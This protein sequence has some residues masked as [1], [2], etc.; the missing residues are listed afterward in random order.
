[1]IDI[2]LII[3]LIE[4]MFRISTPLIIAAMGTL[5]A[6][7]SGVI[8]LAIE[9]QILVGAFAG[10]AVTY[11]FADPYL[12]LLAAMFAAILVAVLLGLA[13]IEGGA[14]QVVSGMSMNILVMGAVPIIGKILFENTGGTPAIEMAQ[15]VTLSPL[16]ITILVPLVIWYLLKNSAWGLRLI[17][18]GERSVAVLTAGYSVR[19]LRWQAYLLSG[20]LGG[21]A[22]WI[23]SV[24]LSS[25]FSRGMS[26]GRGFIALAA[27][28]MGRWQP[29]PTVVV[30]LFFGLSEAVQIQL[31][32]IEV[33]GQKVPV[34]FIQILPY[35][36]ALV[37]V[38]GFMMRS[39]A[40]ADLGK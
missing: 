1:M 30:C 24:Y 18:S 19:W 27:M 17:F 31:Q 25:G 23:L 11:F 15:R 20:A 28:I 36:L 29:I 10:A 2:D 7:R 22:G 8:N 39:R 38:G 6:E 26:G 21:V 32:G 13:C 3:S 35:V 40:P 34:Q 9:G 12:G 4:S 5:I 33:L 14:E 16:I 37:V